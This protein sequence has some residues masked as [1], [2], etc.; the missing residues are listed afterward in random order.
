MEEQTISHGANVA[1]ALAKECQSVKKTRDRAA[2]ETIGENS[3]EELTYLRR[4]KRARTTPLG[5]VAGD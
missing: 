4:S 2:L 5:D 1:E 3:A